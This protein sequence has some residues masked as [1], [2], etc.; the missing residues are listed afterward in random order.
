MSQIF[1]ANTPVTHGD[2]LSSAQLLGI[3]LGRG[4]KDCSAEML[5]LE[6]LERFDG[7]GGVSQADY[8]SLKRVKGIGPGG[9]RR[10]I[11]A[12]ELVKR[13]VA[14]ERTPKKKISE[15][16]DVWEILGPHMKFLESE[17]F[18][19]LLLGGRNELL[20]IVCIASGQRDSCVVH[21]SD[22]FRE[23]LLE[24]ACAII[25]VHNH[26]SGD[27][28]PSPEDCAMTRKV[29]SGAKLMGVS[30]LDHIIIGGNSYCSLRQEGLID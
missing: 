25:L 17:E 7:I 26:P 20:R 10:I 18:R 22:I 24:K 23:A 9:A 2:S 8:S 21:S 15:A 6:L 5:G 3:I 29:V 16:L 13:L 11:A 27:P 30:V 28:S 4:R 1:T 14:A 19:V 12:C